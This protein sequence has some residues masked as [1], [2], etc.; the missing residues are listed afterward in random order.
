MSVG[1][2]P[3]EVL[4][5]YDTFPEE[6]RLTLG[7]FQLEF[8][9][10]KEIL[11]RTLPQP[12]ALIVDVGGAA[13]AYSFWLAERG[14]DVHL[15]DL[16]ERLVAEARRRS[17]RVDRPLASCCTGDARSLPHPDGSADAVLVMGPLYHLPERSDRLRALGEAVRVARPNA[18]IVVAAISRYASTI[19]GLACD[20]ARDPRFV[21]MRNRDLL[22]GQHRNTAGVLE[23]FTTAYFH[24]PEDLREEMEGAGLEHVSVLGVEGPGAV[25]RD[26]MD[27][28]ADQS[29]REDLVDIARR[30]ESEPSILGVSP[31]LLGIG[32]TR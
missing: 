20:R 29:A 11:S 2:P 7:P 16:S 27:R 9:R 4:D 14:Y 15:V 32:R 10:T 8:E 6:S 5:Y 23:Y 17:E 13:G 18:V 25:L 21:E 3:R 22:D 19:D 26:F 1:D 12:P 24:R 31:H 30:L 28:W